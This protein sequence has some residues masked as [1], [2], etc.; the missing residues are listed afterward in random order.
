MVGEWRNDQMDGYGV[1]N[2]RNGTKY[3]GIIKNNLKNGKGIER[4]ING[5][6]Y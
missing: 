2:E 5:D 3:E 4:Y 6:I 1:I